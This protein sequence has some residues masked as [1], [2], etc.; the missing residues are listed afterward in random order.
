MII[1]GVCNANVSGA[2]LFVNGKVIASVNEERFSRRKNH[3]IFPKQSIEYCLG[4][5]NLSIADVDYVA[6]G[7]WGGV[8]A[9]YLPRVVEELLAAS[10]KDPAAAKLINDRTKVATKSDTFYKNELVDSLLALGFAKADIKTHDHHMS[11]AYTAFFP[12]HF[13]E[14]IVFTLDGRGDLKSATISK[15]TRKNGLE[16]LDSTSMYNSIGAFYGFITRYLGFS[17]DRHE[18]KVTGL[19]ALGN[20]DTCFSILQ[21]MISFKD[22]KIIANIGENYSPFLGAK[23]PKIESQLDEHS[24]EDVAAAAQKLT[25]DI[26]LAYLQKFLSETKI[27]NVCLSGG[28]FGNVKLNQRIREM[29]DVDDIYV[30]PQMGDGG[31]GF[32]GGLI[33]LYN[34][35]KEF[36]Y[37]LEDVFL[38]P[39]YNNNEIKE[40]LAK[41]SDQLDWQD[42][43]D[44]GL[45]QIAK[46]LAGGTIVGVF[47]GRME[48]GPRSLGARSIIASASDANINNT[49]NDRLHRTE[50]MPF[51]PVTLEDYA[52]T[53]YVGWDASQIS[54]HFMTVCYECKP[55]ASSE[56]PAIVHVDN[57]ARPQ[58]INKENSIPLYHDILV[59]YHK[60]TGIATLINTSFNNH[61]EPIVC[62]P[63]D[64]IDSLL[65]DNVDYVIMEDVVVKKIV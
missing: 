26:S 50:F 65:K 61:E 54:A 14:A 37:P 42:I 44:Y 24:K 39:S 18:G 41:H 10:S 43:K 59:A 11:H 52:D 15:A 62:S 47:A 45:S 30:F 6:C 40:Q 38:G 19:A 35:G 5:A 57:T 63:A 31:N 48:F 1:L 2:M 32:G 12:S 34:Q 49:L 21:K 55:R 56:C 53:Y 13:D 3:R 36:S 33:E 51:A 4:Q 29:D 7:A 20:P 23:M 8:D 64:A 27:R 17:P 58:I 16:L 46:D 9:E 28:V 60:L 25:E 22:G